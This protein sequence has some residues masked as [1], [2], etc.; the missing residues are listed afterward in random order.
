MRSDANIQA[1]KDIYAAFQTENA[2]A[3]TSTTDHGDDAGIQEL[4]DDLLLGTHEGMMGKSPA[5]RQMKL[6]FPCKLQF[7]FSAR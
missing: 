6:S 4:F 3:Q 5:L 7:E 1:V 2:S